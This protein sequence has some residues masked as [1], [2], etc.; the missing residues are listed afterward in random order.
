MQTTL[1]RMLVADDPDIDV[2][3]VHLANGDNE[4][5]SHKPEIQ[6]CERKRVIEACEAVIAGI[7]E[8]EEREQHRSR[9][10]NEPMSCPGS[11]SPSRSSGNC[12][13]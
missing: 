10:R 4:F 5:F 7:R 12:P 8:V 11:G 6:A 9:R 13:A 3:I 1:L 2:V